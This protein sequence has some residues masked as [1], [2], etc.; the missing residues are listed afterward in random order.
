MLSAYSWLYA[1]DHWCSR[2]R[3]GYQEEN[4]VGH[5]QNKHLICNTIMLVPYKFGAYSWLYAQDH[6][7]SGPYGVPG[8]ET[9]LAMCSKPSALS[10]CHHSGPIKVWFV[11]FFL[12]KV[13]ES[14]L[15]MCRC[16]YRLCAQELFPA[17]S[18]NNVGCQRQ[19]PG[20]LCAGQMLYS[21]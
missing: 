16:Y 14:H 3:M 8:R 19:N 2:D 13:L 20:Q 5:V 12:F 11:G 1:Q 4:Q 21:L 9:K 15:H 10:Q 18:Q 17:K 7:C 6:W